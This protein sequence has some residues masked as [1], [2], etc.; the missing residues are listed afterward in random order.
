[1]NRSERRG[2]LRKQRA[3]ARRP[4]WIL[5]RPQPGLRSCCCWASDSGDILCTCQ[6]QARSGA[7]DANPKQLLEALE[8]QLFCLDQIRAVAG[9]K[10]PTKVAC[11]ATQP[12]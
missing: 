4:T 12:R 10:L 8:R 7:Y 3:A 11:F 2:P 1:M 5:L 6:L 9:Q